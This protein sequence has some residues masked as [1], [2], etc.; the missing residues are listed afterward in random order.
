MRRSLPELAV[1]VLALAG[2]H[3]LAPRLPA[4]LPLGQLM[5]S[6]AALLLL[7]GLLRDLY[8]LARGRRGGV[9]DVRIEARCM[10]V[11]SILGALG[12]V[13]GGAVL[14]AGAGGI[15]DMPASRWTLA[16]AAV[17][18]VGFL[19]K[20]LVIDLANPA[21][22]VQRDHLNVVFRWRGR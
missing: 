4:E 13:A 1:I 10:C 8:I 5:L 20:D 3:V 16:G 14:L 9:D 22:R 19:I 12:I 6:A 2:L 17:L 7:Q 18:V 11:E 21:V 15:V